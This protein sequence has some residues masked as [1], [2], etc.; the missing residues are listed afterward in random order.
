MTDKNVFMVQNM[1]FDMLITVNVCTE[2]KVVN[3]QHLAKYRKIAV[4]FRPRSM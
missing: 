2:A 1:M 3:F 4:A